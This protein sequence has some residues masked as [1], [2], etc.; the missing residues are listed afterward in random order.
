[1]TSHKWRLVYYRCSF[2]I[3]MCISLL[4]LSA[5]QVTEENGL[6]SSSIYNIDGANESYESMSTDDDFSADADGGTKNEKVPITFSEVDA[7]IGESVTFSM[8]GEIAGN[9]Y[10][11][12]IIVTN[13]SDFDLYGLDFDITLIGETGKEQTTKHYDYDDNILSKKEM[14]FSF[15]ADI[16]AIDYSIDW[17][18]SI[19][20][21]VDADSFVPYDALGTYSSGGG[22]K[23]IIDG[24]YITTYYDNGTH[25]KRNIR[26][27]LF[28][29]EICLLSDY[30]NSMGAVYTVRDG[31]LYWHL[32][33]IDDSGKISLYTSKYETE[34]YSHLTRISYST[35]QLKAPTI[36]MT[37]D[38][39]RQST[40]GEPTKINKTTTAYGV[41]EQWVYSSSRY[42]YIDDGVVTAIQ[43]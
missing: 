3:L 10:K 7:S 23:V 27:V 12:I 24:E 4:C 29:N 31:E 2:A 9:R 13:E 39:V 38:E 42:I 6:E 11:Y 30:K 19:A 43:E 8:N 36:G 21:P 37:A 20:F 40:W 34:T 17:T 33:D 28:N 14:E 18:Y 41:R 15:E 32:V 35:E 1:M 26:A 5:C 16:M 25:I 22:S